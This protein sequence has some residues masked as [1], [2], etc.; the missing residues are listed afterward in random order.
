MVLKICASEITRWLTRLYSPPPSQNVWTLNKH[1]EMLHLMDY[2]NS[3]SYCTAKGNKQHVIK[4]RLDGTVNIPWFN[5]IIMQMLWQHATMLSEF[6][7]KKKNNRASGNL[8]WNK[9]GNAQQAWQ[10]SLDRTSTWTVSPIS[11]SAASAW[12]AKYF[13]LFVLFY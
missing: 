1:W 11:L 7:M 13:Q 2:S 8:K 9:G 10:H 6:I 4:A 12:P 3:G 5:K